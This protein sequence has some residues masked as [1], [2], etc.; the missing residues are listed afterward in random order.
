MATIPRMAFV[1]FL[2]VQ[3][4]NK[5]IQRF[6]QYG[7]TKGYELI[8]EWN[9]PDLLTGEVK[10]MQANL[11]NG[12]KAPQKKLDVVACPQVVG[13]MVHESA[14]HP[15]E[16]DRIFGRE[17]AQAGESFIEKDMMGSKIGNE[18]VN[19]VDDPTLPNSYGFYLYDN[20]GVKARRKFL[21]KEGKMNELLHNR[22]TAMF[23]GLKSNGSSRAVDYNRES[24]VRMSNTFMLPGDHKE[25]ELIEDVKE[26]IYMKNFMIY[27]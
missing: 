25:E 21:I 5:S 12:V 20:E 7:A 24:I 3:E 10:A 1:Y 14:G 16:A 13:I 22:E 4:N 2:T 8:K 26:G 27:L 17:A 18:V 9:M 23:M 11:K 6:W 15:Y 19:V